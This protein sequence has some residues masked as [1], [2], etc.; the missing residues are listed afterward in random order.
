MRI[1]HIAAQRQF[2]AELFAEVQP[3]VAGRG[4]T[5]TGSPRA[6]AALSAH[7]GKH[8][9]GNIGES[10][11]VRIVQSPHDG[12]LVVV[13]E[14]VDHEISFVSVVAAISGKSIPE[15]SLLHPWLDSQ[16]DDGLFIPVIESGHPRH[17]AQTIQDLY[18][19]DH[20]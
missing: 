1:A 16:V 12:D 18:F 19:F 2:L 10:H 8:V 11:I 15:P 20:F 6:S 17:I 4:D 5:V 9:G 14:S 13:D 3:H 7:A